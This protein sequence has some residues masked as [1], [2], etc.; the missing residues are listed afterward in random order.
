MP[1]LVLDETSNEVERFLHPNNNQLITAGE[2]E[3]NKMLSSRGSFGMSPQPRKW[4][5][6]QVE[7]CT[8]PMQDEKKKTSL[9][10]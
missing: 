1:N 10:L 3:M 6:G 9:H 5:S 7:K 4:T 2:S 8:F